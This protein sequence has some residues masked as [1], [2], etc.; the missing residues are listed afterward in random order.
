MLGPQRQERVEEIASNRSSLW[1][2]VRGNDSWLTSEI[3]GYFSGNIS[4]QK[5]DLMDC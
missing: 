5:K 1:L 4:L 2:S 3:E